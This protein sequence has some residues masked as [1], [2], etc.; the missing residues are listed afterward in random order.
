MGDMLIIFYGNIRAGKSTL[1]KGVAKR[2]RCPCITFDAVVPKIYR[3]KLYAPGKFLL[4]RSEI[5]KVYDLMHKLA[6]L[7]IR[8]RD[9]VVLESVY[10]KKQRDAAIDL[11]KS[12][13]Q[14]WKLVHVACSDSETKKRLVNRYRSNGQTADYSLFLQYELLMDKD[15]R[16]HITI[17]TTGKTKAQC[18][19]ETLGALK[20]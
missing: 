9:H 20:F 2:L 13:K 3:K 17:N 12:V 5:V 16:K 18:I 19:S 7:E 11:A 1:A 10:F 4:T 8:K 14:R 6:K 15:S